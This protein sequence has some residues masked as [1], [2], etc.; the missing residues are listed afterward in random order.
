MAIWRLI[1]AM[2]AS[3]LLGLGTTVKVMGPVWLNVK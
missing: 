2:Q 1:S 3:T